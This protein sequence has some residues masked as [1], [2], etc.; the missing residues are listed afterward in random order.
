MNTTAREIK[1]QAR[2]TLEGR[3]A[4]AV[5]LTVSYS[6][7]TY[8][9]N[10]LLSISGLNTSSTSGLVLYIVLYIIIMLLGA[11]LETGLIRFLYL[12]C[13]R[14][15]ENN[16]AGLF[17]AFRAQPDTFIITIAV[18]YALVF[19][20]FVPAIIV[21]LNTPVI[22][23]SSNIPSGFITGTALYAGLAV[24]GLIPALYFMMRFAFSRYFLLDEPLIS[25]KEALR[26]SSDLMR[27]N[28]WKVLR[29]WIGF[30]PFAL[31]SLGSLGI[32]YFWVK[33][34][35]HTAMGH[36]YMA[37]TG[38]AAAQDTYDYGR[39]DYNGYYAG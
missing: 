15:Y 32:G 36:M 24:I 22:T 27:G 10:M 13:K 12:M 38:R 8:A 5:S 9:L 1:H 37:L 33:P 6:L 18:R 23:D 31:L 29:L 3:Y 16:R 21:Y 35:Y 7:F 11:L 30:I 14:D 25:A 19:V 4:P 34:Y 2:L 17:Y 39:Q 28:Y 20:C 26:K